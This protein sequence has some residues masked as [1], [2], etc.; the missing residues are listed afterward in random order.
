MEPHYFLAIP[1]PRQINSAMMKQV[2][3]H[4]Q[5]QFKR[6]VH[7]EDLHLTL[8]FLGECSVKRL[9]QVRHEARALVGKWTPFQL[10]LTEFG[11][12]GRLEQPRIFW[13]GVKKQPLLELCREELFKMCQEVGF[14]LDPRPFTPH[15][16]LA[17]KWVGDED[18]KRFQLENE[19]TFKSSWLV[20]DIVLYKNQLTE[21][22]KYKVI[23]RFSFGGRQI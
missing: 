10:E 6:W 14:P 9:E 20:N 18:Y 21:E 12:F 1:V 13:I 2:K 4:R 19:E 11:S 16:T 15:I 22:P 3:G 8:V 7:P 5:L 23:E 17:R